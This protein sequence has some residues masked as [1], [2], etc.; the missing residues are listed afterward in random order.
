MVVPSHE[1]I[2]GDHKQLRMMVMLINTGSPVRIG[3]Q[4]SFWIG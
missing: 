1:V 3:A 4:T 2:F